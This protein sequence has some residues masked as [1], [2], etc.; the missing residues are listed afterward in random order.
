VHE[1]QIWANS[2]QTVI[3]A[4]ALGSSHTLGAVDARGKNL[5]SRREMDIVRSVAQGLTN[6]EIAER[7]ELSPHTIK[8]C[9]FRVFDKLGVANRVELLLMTMRQHCHAQSG[10]LYF[11][12]DYGDAMRDEAT[13]VA[14]QRAAEQGVLMAQLA[15]AQFHAS[16]RKNAG[17]A[18]DAYQWYSVA[19]ERISQ[20][21]KEA[22]KTM[23]V[24]QVI[25]AEQMTARQLDNGG[26]APSMCAKDEARHRRSTTKEKAFEKPVG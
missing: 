25:Q 12:D 8:N 13:L 11:L 22:T 3:L 6:R 14:C 21:L 26:K 20:A 10:L 9:L 23:T 18:L 1:G 16:R 19:R 7:L 15:L 5:L 17:D 2:E 24:D 4:Q